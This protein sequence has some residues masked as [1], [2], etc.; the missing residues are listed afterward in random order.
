MYGVC[1]YGVCGCGVCVWCAFHSVVVALLPF[2][3]V[4]AFVTLQAF[5]RVYPPSFVSMYL[6]RPLNIVP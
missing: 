4:T 6:R 5:Y 2:R 3:W 1:V